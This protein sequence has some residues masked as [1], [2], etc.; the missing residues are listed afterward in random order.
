MR[1]LILS[2]FLIQG[3]KM[4]YEAKWM[5]VFFSGTI[6]FTAAGAF[7]IG[8]A[9]PDNGPEA[10]HIVLALLSFAVMLF[11][12]MA[13]FHVPTGGTPPKTRKAIPDDK[14]GIA[15]I[16]KDLQKYRRSA[17]VMGNNSPTVLSS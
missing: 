10:W 4:D 13:L 17:I 7:I 12:I 16:Y 15:L 11:A 9:P 5:T 2:V 1:K 8:Q 6:G 14:E 3:E